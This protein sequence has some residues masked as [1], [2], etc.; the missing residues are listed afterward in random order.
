MTAN[1]ISLARGRLLPFLLPNL[2]DL[3]PSDDSQHT[4]EL[5]RG[6][7]DRT[8]DLARSSLRISAEIAPDIDRTINH[9]C[10]KI[11][12]DRDSVDLYVF[13]SAELSGFCFI[14]EFPI[15]VGASSSVI[16]SLDADELAFFLGH[17][18]GHALF[19]E[20]S[21]FISSQSCLEDQIFARSIEITVDRVGLLTAGNMDSAFSAILKTLSG[22]DDRHLRF[23]FS[24]FMS[25]A[26]EALDGSISDQLLYSSHP[27]LAQRFKALVSFSLSDVYRNAVNGDSGGAIPIDQINKVIAASLNNAVDSKAYELINSALED[28]G[29]WVIHLLIALKKKISL[30]GL[31]DATGL[32]V[33]KAQIERA[34]IFLDSYSE[35]EKL[36][37]LNEK[38]TDSLR[39]SGR[40]APRATARLMDKIQDLYPGSGLDVEELLGLTDG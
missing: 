33:N 8:V 7:S 3:S 17:E 21:N 39:H 11:S 25:E 24:H 14:N 28:F 6:K 4:V 5:L 37:V 10:D 40:L 13:P 22:L 16:K 29:V 34:G 15:I 32:A 23:D 9:V 1:Q 30:S 38:L 27:P 19:K 31:K 20:T 2:R 12:I 35:S 26:R 18:I 36:Q